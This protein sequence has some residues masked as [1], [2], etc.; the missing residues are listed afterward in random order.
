ML[1]RATVQQCDGRSAEFEVGGKKTNRLGPVNNRPSAST[2]SA[3]RPIE[4]GTRLGVYVPVLGEQSPKAKGA[5]RQSELYDAESHA[6]L[7]SLNIRY[8]KT[9]FATASACSVSYQ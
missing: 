4:S 5:A 8:K 1:K 3:P 7:G 2:E 6:Y 9:S